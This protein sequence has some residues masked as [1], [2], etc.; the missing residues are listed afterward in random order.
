MDSV[1]LR[2]AAF[3][4]KLTPNFFDKVFTTCF[5]MA[6]AGKPL[7]LVATSDIEYFG[8][9]AFLNP[10]K[11]KGRTISLAGDM[12]TFEGMGLI[13]EQKTGQP[14]PMIFRPICS[15]FMAMMKD[16]GY[17]FQWY[18]KEGYRADIPRLR[19]TYPKMM[20]FATWLKKELDSRDSRIWKAHVMYSIMIYPTA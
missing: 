7:Q 2:P 3:F 15:F 16:M 6:L 17:I 11:Y 12:L 10:E 5:K 8:A 4:E 14:L 1:I 18:R 19:E 13:F 20:D 9:E